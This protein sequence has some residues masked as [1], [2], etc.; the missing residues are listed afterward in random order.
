LNYK[1]IVKL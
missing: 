1:T